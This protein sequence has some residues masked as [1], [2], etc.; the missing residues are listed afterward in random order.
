MLFEY[1]IEKNNWLK[2]NRSIS[3]ETVI[4]YVM[5]GKII[6]II[7]NPARENQYMYV[8]K[9]ENLIYVCPFVISVEGIFLKTIFPDRRIAKLYKEKE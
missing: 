7:H 4:T 9:Y 3:F 5:E 8:F 1:S 2:R 6:D